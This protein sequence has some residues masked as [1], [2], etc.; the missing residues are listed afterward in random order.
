MD[1]GPLVVHFHKGLCFSR[2]VALPMTGMKLDS[3]FENSHSFD[4]TGP[5][6]VTFVI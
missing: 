5:T 3:F 1:R 4:L 2:T 6:I